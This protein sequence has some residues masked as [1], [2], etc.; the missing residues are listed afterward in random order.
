[1]SFYNK[2][3]SNYIPHSS[4]S[5]CTAPSDTARV[6]RLSL[7]QYLWLQVVIPY[8]KNRVQLDMCQDTEIDLQKVKWHLEPWFHILL[9]FGTKKVSILKHLLMDTSN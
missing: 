6:L 9:T 3:L 7:L 8:F 5:G 4:M 2:E 1:M